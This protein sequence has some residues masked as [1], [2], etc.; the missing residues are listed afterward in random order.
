[1]AWLPAWGSTSKP[2]GA[3][4]TSETAGSEEY[5]PPGRQTRAKCWDSRDVFNEC[6]NRNNI[7]DAIKDKDAADKACGKESDLFE[8]N[9]ASS[10]VTYFKQRRVAE[11]EKEQ[12]L[13]KQEAQTLAS[14]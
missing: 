7:L 4:S 11:Y 6:L 1:M 12:M 13:K 9:C 3:S 10:W 5:R 8:K 14:R 2:E